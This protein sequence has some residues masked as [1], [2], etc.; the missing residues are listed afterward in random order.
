MSEN[1]QHT[2]LLPLLEDDDWKHAFEY[3]SGRTDSGNGGGTPE[4]ARPG[5][6]VDTSP[7]D[8]EDVIRILGHS[9]GEPDEEEWLI[10]MEL[11]DGRFAML[12]AGCDYTGWD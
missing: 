3:S 4:G 1:T 12:E 8:R 10:A 2:A 9:E 5:S 6:P 11:R 7:F